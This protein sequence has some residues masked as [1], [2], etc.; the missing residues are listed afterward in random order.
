MVRLFRGGCVMNNQ[1]S[2]LNEIYKIT[3]DSLRNRLSN[4][5]LAFIGTRFFLLETANETQFSNDLIIEI[6]TAFK[7]ITFDEFGLQEVFNHDVRILMHAF[8]LSKDLHNAD[9]P[10]IEVQTKLKEVK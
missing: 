10:S 6:L 2:R 9:L 7:E 1:I 8:E 5:E 3:I 4:E